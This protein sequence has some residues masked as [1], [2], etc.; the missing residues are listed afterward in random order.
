MATMPCKPVVNSPMTQVFFIIAS[1]G[2][3]GFST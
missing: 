3:V 1:K 2:T